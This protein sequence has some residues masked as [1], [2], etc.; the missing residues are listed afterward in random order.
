MDLMGLGGL[1]VRPEMAIRIPKVWKNT[2]ESIGLAIQRGYDPQG[3]WS[4]IGVPSGN[5]KM[6]FKTGLWYYFFTNGTTIGPFGLKL[7]SSILTFRGAPD[8]TTPDLPNT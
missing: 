1:P 3:P 8:G 5:P 4:H 7:F 2:I 6:G